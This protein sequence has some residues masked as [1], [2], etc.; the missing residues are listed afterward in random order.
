MS[1]WTEAIQ[2]NLSTCGLNLFFRP[3]QSFGQSSRAK[4]F[5]GGLIRERLKISDVVFFELLRQC[6]ENL[7]N[8][9]CS[10]PSEA[11]VLIQAFASLFPWFE[12]V[13][14]AI[15]ALRWREIPNAEF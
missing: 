8:P 12:T 13:P 9:A 10:G 2:L 11:N 5:R 15:L 4:K 6:G 7:E 1:S 14:A 3:F